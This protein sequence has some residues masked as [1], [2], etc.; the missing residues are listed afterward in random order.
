MVKMRGAE[1]VHVIRAV[2]GGVAN[3]IS[4]VA[5]DITGGNVTVVAV[6]PL[7]VTAD[8]IAVYTSCCSSS[9]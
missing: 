8:V 5:G 3:A 7:V 1:F 9:R 6:S 4:V 2:I